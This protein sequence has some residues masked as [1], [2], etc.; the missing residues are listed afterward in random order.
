MANQLGR[1]ELAL[2]CTLTDLE[3][4]SRGNMLGETVGSIDE[5]N[6]SLTETRKRFKEKLVGLNETQRKLA[7]ILHER[8]EERMV[9]C[10]VQFHT[11]CEGIKRVIRMDTGEVVKENPMTNSEKQLNLFDSQLEFRKFM[12]SQDVAESVTSD[13]PDDEVA[14]PTTSQD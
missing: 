5:T 6:R 1:V 9:D 11:P 2:M 12:E 14:P 7:R 4:Q 3:V 10:V 13:A 8:A